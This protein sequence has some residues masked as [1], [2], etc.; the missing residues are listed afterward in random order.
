MPVR[1]AAAARPKFRLA[2]LI[3]CVAL[4][5]SGAAEA[6]YPER[7]VKLVVPF[8]PGGGTDIIARTLAE[9]MGKELGQ[10]VIVD[11]KPGAGTIIGTG[12]VA[13]SAPD[14]YT[15]L[16][17]TFAHA[18]N[19]SLYAKL[20][21]DTAKAFAPVSLVA[22]SFNVVVVHPERKFRSVADLIAEA[23]AKPGKLN[24]GSFGIGTS[25][26]LAGELFK[27]LAQ[28][29]LVHVPYKGSAPAITDLL[30]GQIDVM[31]TTVAGVAAYLQ[32]GQLR[33]LAVTASE[34][35]P[36]YPDLPTVAEAGLPGYVAESW[37]GV[38]A[39]AATPSE[40]I[41]RLNRSVVLAVRSAAFQRL[42]QAEGLTLAAGPPAELDRYVRGE[43]ARWRQVVRDA[44]IQSE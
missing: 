12:A 19:P 7:V 20:P 8:A 17:A 13:T 29:D 27:S 30:G 1:I 14:G 38:Y 44:N 16:M 35:S 5:A 25:A 32:S 26:H 3:T 22:R 23:K 42:E 2:L 33:A 41:E 37:Y 36:A 10:T 21:Y 28:V 39:P 18:V 40:I 9:A 34:R 43:E 4:L 15:L 24:Y 11:N 31:F 6:A